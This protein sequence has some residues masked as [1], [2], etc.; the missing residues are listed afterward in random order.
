MSHEQPFR[1]RGLTALALLVGAALAAIAC[2]LWPTIASRAAIS[3]VSVFPI[4]G[5]RLAAPSTQLD[6]RE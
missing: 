2:W 1:G 3:P 4:P 6:L 5:G